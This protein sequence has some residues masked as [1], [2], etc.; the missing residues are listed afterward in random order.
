MHCYVS[1]VHAPLI[2]IF[3]CLIQFALGLVHFQV[4]AYMHVAIYPLVNFSIVISY[5]LIDRHYDRNF[6]LLV[7]LWKPFRKC[8]KFKGDV[9][10]KPV[11]INAF[12]TFIILS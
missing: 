9:D 1:H 10:V 4:F 5:V 6:C 12:V 11:F 2:L 7:W 8:L 3:Y